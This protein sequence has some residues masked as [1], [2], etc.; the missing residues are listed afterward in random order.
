MF[1][2]HQFHIV[3]DRRVFLSKDLVSDDPGEHMA[4]DGPSRNGNGQYGK[5][6]NY[7]GCD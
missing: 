3:D 2:Q 6:E 1:L 5:R 4:G 7:Q